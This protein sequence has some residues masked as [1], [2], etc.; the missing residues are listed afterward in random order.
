VSLRGWLILIGFVLLAVPGRAQTSEQA[1]SKYS[2][3]DEFS[4][5][6]EARLKA[7]PDRWDKIPPPL[8]PV[9]GRSS[10][11]VLAI[12]TA[13]RAFAREPGSADAGAPSGSEVDFAP[14]GTSPPAESGVGGISVDIGGLEQ[15][16]GG[17]SAPYPLPQSR[18]TLKAKP[19]ESSTKVCVRWSRSMS[20]RP[21][22]A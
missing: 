6:L 7:L 16:G 1:D 17:G 5:R 9:S 13:R 8:V 20:S 4:A 22:S 18:D 15:A 21:R 3:L 14:G 12:R 2:C 10:K 19:S 11:E